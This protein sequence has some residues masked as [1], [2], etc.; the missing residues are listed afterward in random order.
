[1]L[2]EENTEHSRC[3]IF[4]TEH[5]WLKFYLDTDFTVLTPNNYFVCFALF[6]Y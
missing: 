4:L 6:K 2:T 5:E 3:F 1:M